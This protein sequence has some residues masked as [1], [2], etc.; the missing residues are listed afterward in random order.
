MGNERDPSLSD[1]IRAAMRARLM[2][3][4]TALPGKVVTYDATTGIADVQPLIQQ[5]RRQPDGTFQAKDFPIVRGCPVMFPRCAGGYITFPIAADDLGLI[6]FCEREIGDWV[7]KAP[8]E[9]VDPGDGELDPLMGCTFYPGLYPATSP[10]T[11]SNTS[12][13]VIHAN[14]TGITKLQ[15]DAV[16]FVAN[17]TKIKTRLDALYSIFSSWTAVPNDGGA[18]L[19]TALGL[20]G[21]AGSP[22]PVPPTT[23][24]VAFTKVKAK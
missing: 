23:N 16:D 13:I 10:V 20:G 11:P 5:R 3:L 9:S 15:S 14:G 18:A 6:I 2:D 4:H 21:W 22:G 12:D 1:V 8:G 17:A 19:K 24:D 7:Q